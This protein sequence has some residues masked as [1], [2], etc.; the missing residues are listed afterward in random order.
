MKKERNTLEF[1]IYTEINND[2]TSGRNRREQEGEQASPR[3]SGWVDEHKNKASLWV[4]ERESIALPGC[5]LLSPQ[6]TEQCP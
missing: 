4:G 5:T 3:G 2:K 1:H 6:S